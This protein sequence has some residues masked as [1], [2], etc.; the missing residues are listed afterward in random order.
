MNN[1]VCI[2]VFLLLGVGIMSLSSCKRDKV[3]QS[4]IEGEVSI[5]VDE[6]IKPLI[7]DQVEVFEN[8]YRAKIDIVSLSEMEAVNA[9][10]EDTLDIAILTRMLNEQEEGVFVRKKITPR[11]T[12]F[13][14]DAIALI[15]NTTANDST[16]ELQGVI[17]FMRGNPSTV[18]GLVFDNPNSATMRY[19][20]DLAGIER[21]SNPEIYALGSSPEVIRYISENPEFIGVVGVN[22]LNQAP[23][24][25]DEHMKN[26]KVL[27]VRNVEVDGAD[28]SYYKPTQA[29]IGK[30]LYPLTR[31]LFILNYQGKTGLGMGFASYI[32]GEGGQRIVLRSGLAPLEISP[33]EINIRKEIE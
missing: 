27:A 5:L 22:W 32:A 33:M 16:I 21:G 9:L 15:V 28:D 24:E 19:M 30:R 31:E 6:T 13:A 20:C 1:K 7:E 3:K 2:C 8:I 29:N 23:K 18:S 11:I 17:D 12:R 26:V 10:L 4:I 14:I 25:M